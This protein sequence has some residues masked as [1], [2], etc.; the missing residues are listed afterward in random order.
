LGNY[1]DQ[2]EFIER[3]LALPSA[4][5]CQTGGPMETDRRQHPRFVVSS[6][7]LVSLGIFP[8]GLLFDLS[9][10]GLSVRGLVPH[11]QDE[12]HFVSFRLP[13]SIPGVDCFIEASAA[14]AWK[15]VSEKRLGLRFVEL[16]DRSRRELAEW[17]G[18]R[19]GLIAAEP[20]DLETACSDLQLTGDAGDFPYPPVSRTNAFSPERSGESELAGSPETGLTRLRESHRQF[21]AFLL[22]ALLCIPAV[23]LG[24]YL[25]SLVGNR[26]VERI[27]SRSTTTPHLLSDHGVRQV[28]SLSAPQSN[29]PPRLSLD[30]PGFVLQVAAMRSE[31]N[32]DAF[33]ATLNQMNFPAFVFRH[34][35]DRFYRVAVG[36]Y[37]NVELSSK[38]RV[39]LQRKDFQAILRPWSPS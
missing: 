28:D 29:L 24:Y 11:D 20:A 16:A 32:A 22:A 21:E 19:S 2:I 18:S 31:E 33:A 27:A 13:T 8:A 1:I 10:S 7:A 37:E 17:I 25:P 6:P 39:E 15:R 23:L 30:Q 3:D 26:K 9:E 34:Q 5:Q 38:V 4:Y 14:I 36:P 12:F 35:G